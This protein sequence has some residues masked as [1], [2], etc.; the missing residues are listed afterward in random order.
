[1]ALQAVR[2]LWGAALLL[3]PRALLKR[4]GDRSSGVV[5]ATRI[6]GARHLVEVLILGRR[7]TE[8]RWPVVVDVAHC[9]TMVAVAA[10]SRRLRSDAL[11]SAAVA[12]LLAGWAEMERRVGD[13][14]TRSR[15]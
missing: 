14:S 11:A 12:A 3:L 6:L 8:P 7:G 1:M 10:G 15:P 9:S 2:A 5:V 4:T 13:G